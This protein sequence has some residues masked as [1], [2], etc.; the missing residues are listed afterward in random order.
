[1]LLA[2]RSLEAEQPNRT[3]GSAGTAP[4][5]GAILKACGLSETVSGGDTVTYAPVTTPSDS[6]TLF[7]NYDGIRHM[8][9][10]CRGT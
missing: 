1:M 10:G 8:I 6:V 4:K 5:Y 7:V 2:V 9:T 3:S